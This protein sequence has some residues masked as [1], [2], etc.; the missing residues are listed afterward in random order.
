M[1]LVVQSGHPDVQKG[2]K[3][4]VESQQSEFSRPDTPMFRRGLRPKSC[5][6]LASRYPS[7]HPDVQ[8]GIKTH[9]T[10][11]WNGYSCPDTP[12]F[13][14]GLRLDADGAGV[15]G[16][17]PDTPMFRRGLRQAWRRTCWVVGS[18]HPDVQKGIKTESIWSPAPE[19][20][21]RTPRCSEG[22]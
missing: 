8:K 2:I 4:V 13:R 9:Q 3:T 10:D 11:E 17:C 18:G 16:F 22:D 1:F 20:L 12:M 14:R 6:P 5:S 19:E 21:V 7:G 15:S